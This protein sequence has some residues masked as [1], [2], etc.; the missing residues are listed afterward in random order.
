MNTF[1]NAE[2]FFWIVV[3]EANGM[4]RYPSKH[5]TEDSAVKEAERL[6]RLHGGR[7]YILEA[8]GYAA[9]ND[10]TTKQFEAPLPF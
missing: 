7:F 8:R 3:S 1:D 9:R 5:T 6:A 4:A 2:G 10:V